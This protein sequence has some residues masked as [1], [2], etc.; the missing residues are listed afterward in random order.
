[1]LRV[2]GTNDFLDLTLYNFVIEQIR[3][4]LGIYCF[5]QIET[6]ILEH[7]ELFKRTLGLHTDVVNK[8]MFLIKPHARTHHEAFEGE[9]SEGEQ[10]CLRPEITAS[11]VRAFVDNG[12]QITPWKVFT[13]GPCFRYERP[14]KGR[15]R[16]FHQVSMEV[17]GS[18]PVAQDVQMI[19]ML[20]RLFHETLKFNNYA[21]LINYLGCPAD[22]A[23]YKEK[24]KKFLD[25]QT[26]L[27]SDC[28]VR[29]EKNIMRIFDCKVETCQKIYQNAP[30]IIDYLC[31]TCQEEWQTLQHDLELLSVTFVV[32]PKLVRGLDYY[33]KT[34]FEFVSGALGAQNTFCGGGRYDQLVTQIGGKTDQQSIGA[35]IGIER[36]LLLLEPFKDS[37]ALP[38]P[39]KLHAILP[40]AL[41]Q[42]MLALLLADELQAV[43][44]CTEV[45]L[46]GASIKSMMNRANKLGAAYALI[47]GADEQ[48]KNQVTVKNMI[49]GA[50]ET[51]P[52]AQMVAYLQ[53]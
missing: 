9:E 49:T 11:M 33:N 7:T 50:Q 10:L 26:G 40:L 32:Q 31:K 16:E 1:M 27:C 38:H 13:I 24:L 30:H 35:A 48:Q 8:E 39:P 46:E 36:L 6:P 5:N 45:L 51:I 4:H 44:L 12:I 19:K 18:A 23:V 15:F 42:Q 14:Q 29:K 22:R 21:L 28:M 3:K 17:I 34:V 41:E 2:K 20:D 52:Q 47:L 53:K 25:A 43:G 37:L